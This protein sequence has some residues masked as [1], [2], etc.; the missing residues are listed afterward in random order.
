VLIREQ[1]ERFEIRDFL[2]RGAVADVYLAWDP[3]REEEIALK[4]LRKGSSDPEMLQ[5]ERN[6]VVLQDRIARVSPQVA[7][8]HEQGEDD[9]LFW[10]VM[11]YVDGEDLSKVLDR[12]ALPVDRSLAIASQLCEMLEAFHDFSTEIGGR[13]V[14]GVVHGDL[15]PENIRLQDGDRVRVLDFGI[16]KHLSQTRR[17][18]V[19]LFGSL[20]Y[21]PPERLDRGIVDHHSDLWAVGVLLYL[22][23]SGQRPFPGETAEEL[24]QW[25]RQRRP[26][27]PLP[28]S[29]PPGLRRVVYRTLA[30]DPARRYP[31]A[32]ALRADVQALLEGRPPTDEAGPAAPDPSATRR[33]A[34]PL[35]DSGSWPPPLPNPPPPPAEATRRTV[36]PPAMLFPEDGA[37]LEGEPASRP[38]PRRLRKV[39]AALAAVLILAVLASQAWVRGEAAEIRDELAATSEPDLDAVLARYREAE[40]ATLYT[41][42]G[43]G[44]AREELREALTREAENILRAY[45]GDDP[46]STETG[47]RRAHE[48]LQKALELDF[49]DLRTRARRTYARAHLDRIEAQTLRSRGERE[50]ADRKLNQAINGFRLAARRDSEWADPYLGLTRIYAYERFDLDRLQAAVGELRRRGYPIGRRE[51]AMLGDGF[52]MRGQE[53]QARANGVRGT[54]EEERFLRQAREHYEQAIDFYDEIPSYANVRANRT[55]AERRLGEVEARLDETDLPGFLERLLGGL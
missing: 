54:D 7:A 8:V 55:L 46:R 26:P 52:R 30:A 39:L 47:W 48:Y 2:G 16:A 45:H 17:F 49:T 18:T 53:F 23:V 40:G 1:V 13:T 38:R 33:T 11:E 42:I 43:L 4:V 19:N 29:C 6:G 28:D 50:A 37:P 20:P 34:R 5:A 41:G 36:P 44:A 51:T 15:K 10:V 25:I 12:G 9:G 22:M 32:A 21:T 31:S 3:R 24:E 35:D 27:L 14:H